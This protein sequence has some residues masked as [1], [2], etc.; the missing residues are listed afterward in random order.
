MQTYRITAT[1]VITKGDEVLLGK[2]PKDI[3]PYPN[4]WILPGGGIDFDNET[5]EE[6]LIREINEETG[7]NV[8]NI[9]P[10]IFITDKEPNK[11]GVETYYVHLVYLAEYDSGEIK[12]GDDVEYL[13]WIPIKQIP[14]LTVARP[15]ITTF[16]KLGWI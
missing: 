10:H 14:S 11:K 4:T 7:L 12:A 1:A 3:G 15:S 13:E 2:K 16:K 5:A 8:K 6:A 9:K